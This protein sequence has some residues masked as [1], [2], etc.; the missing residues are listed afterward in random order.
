MT[1]SFTRRKAQGDATSAGAIKSE[2]INEIAGSFF[3]FPWKITGQSGIVFH[4][5]LI[6]RKRGERESKQSK[7]T[8]NHG[9]PDN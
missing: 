7:N 3:F 6:P 8:K 5:F 4:G 9:C 1:G 2:S